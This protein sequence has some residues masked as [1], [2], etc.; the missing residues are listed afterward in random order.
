MGIKNAEFHADFESLEK[1][2]QKKLLAKMSRKY[3]LFLLLLMFVILVLLITF[4]CTFFNI[5]FNGFEISVKFC[6]FWHLFRF[7]QIFLFKGHISTFF[8]LWSQTRKKRL[9]KS[10]NVFCKCVLDFNFEPMEGSVF[11]IF[12]K[13]SNL[14]YPTAQAQ[15]AEMEYLNGICSLENWILNIPRL[16]L[17]S[18]FLPSFFRSCIDF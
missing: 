6:I 11:F 17:L 10:K 14:L 1:M 13:K 2:H 18:G 12:K 7:F 8:K 3:A 5:F 16:E 15:K 9:K 4:F